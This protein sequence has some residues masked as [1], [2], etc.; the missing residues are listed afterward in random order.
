MLVARREQ[1]LKVVSNN[2]RLIG[3]NHVIIIAADVIKEDDCRRFITQA[4]NY[5]GRGTLPTL[6]SFIFYI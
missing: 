2:A 6:T 5:Y 3:A 1:R 4:V